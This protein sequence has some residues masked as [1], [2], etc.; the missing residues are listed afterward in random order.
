MDGSE[1]GREGGKEVE[2][3]RDQNVWRGGGKYLMPFLQALQ[4]ENLLSSLTRNALS[5]S[6]LGPPGMVTTFGQDLLRQVN[7][8]I[9][10][11]ESCWYIGLTNG[12]V[13]STETRVTEFL[14]RKL[15]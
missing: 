6:I 7:K 11:R 14:T 10:S 9:L 12:G 8:N 13:K 3:E 15:K 5:R 1:G 4:C 2:R